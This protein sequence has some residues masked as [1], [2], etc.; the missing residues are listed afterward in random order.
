VKIRG[1]TVSRENP[2]FEA[3]AFDRTVLAVLILTAV[4]FWEYGQQITGPRVLPHDA[5]R[6]PSLYPSHPLG[7]A[8]VCSATPLY[9][10]G[11]GT[12]DNPQPAWMNKKPALVAAAGTLVH[13]VVVFGKNGLYPNQTRVSVDGRGGTSY[14]VWSDQLKDSCP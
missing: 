14:F 13:K 3:K 4:W 12:P 8:F 1:R 7:D 6:D 10:Y 11:I 5:S 9:E 2:L